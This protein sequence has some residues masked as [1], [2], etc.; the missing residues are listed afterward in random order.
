MRY[1]VHWIMLPLRIQRYTMNVNLHAKHS[2]CC[3][4]TPVT[5]SMMLYAR[6]SQLSVLEAIIGVYTI[7]GSR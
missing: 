2:F 1:V 4:S 5:N 7:S 3:D 6:H